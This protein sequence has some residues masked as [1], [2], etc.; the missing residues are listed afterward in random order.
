MIEKS[1][2]NDITSIKETQLQMSNHLSNLGNMKFWLIFKFYR[3][4]CDWE[5]SMETPMFGQRVK[6]AVFSKKN[7]SVLQNINF[8]WIELVITT[9]TFENSQSTCMQRITIIC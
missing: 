9:Y 7:V 8:K 2:E 3:G 6:K 1:I 5:L 4:Y